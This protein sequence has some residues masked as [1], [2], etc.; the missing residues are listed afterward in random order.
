MQYQIS[1]K[2]FVRFRE[3]IYR[4]AGINLSDAKKA[5]L[6]ARLTR[7]IRHLGIETFSEYYDYLIANPEDEMVN[8]INA[9]TTNKTEFFRESRHFHFMIEDAL[10]E[11]DT[12][13]LDTL[14]IWSAGCSSGQEPYT[15]AMSLSEYYNGI[16]KPDIKILATDIDTQMLEKA[17]SGIYPEEQVAEIE[18]QLLRKYFMKGVGSNHGAYRVKDFLKKLISFRRLNLLDE[19]YPMKRKFDIIFCRNVVIY[20]DKPTQKMLFNRLGDNLADHGYLFI[21]HSENIL[22]ITDRFRLIGN[23]IYQKSY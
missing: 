2:D 21:G 23:T 18:D 8:F 1:D 22:N 10:P 7:R 16:K 17:E 6:Q 3:L 19:K 15:I 14:R 5:L 20:F 9:L 11:F 4:E 12:M 13:G